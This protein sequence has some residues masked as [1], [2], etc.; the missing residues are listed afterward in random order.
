MRLRVITETSRRRKKFTPLSD[1]GLMRFETKSEMNEFIRADLF[2]YCAKT[3]GRTLRKY[4]R[5]S[6]GF[7]FTYYMRKC[8]YYRYHRVFRYILFPVYKT[9]KDR[10][11]MKL[12]AE[13]SDLAQVG[14]GLHIAHFG[15]IIIHSD[16]VLG[17]NVSL[18]QGVTVGQTIKDG[19]SFVPTVG[20]SVYLAPGAKVIGGITVGSN[21]AVGANAVVTH[22]LPDNAV[23]AGVPA[24]IL[25]TNGAGDYIINPYK[26]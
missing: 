2:R 19:E 25:N 17:D 18:S 26:G 24:K 22:S 10:A 14:K 7:R 12:G 21:V 15:Q 11:G 16:A 8:S 3:D 13:I 9:L 5:S 23:A 20:N 4:R 1:G 6:L